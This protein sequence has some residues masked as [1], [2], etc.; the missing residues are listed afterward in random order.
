MGDL[1]MARPSGH[2]LSWPHSLSVD[3]DP[4]MC[5][6]LPDT[7]C[8]LGFRDIAHLAVLLLLWLPCLAS[9]SSYS[10]APL[11]SMSFPCP[12]SFA[13][14]LL[15]CS[16]FRCSTASYR[17]SLL[18]LS[19]EVVSSKLM[20]LNLYAVYLWPDTHLEFQVHGLPLISPWKL[21]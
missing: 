15:S 18:C 19:S 8:P 9:I 14:C 12:A 6:C 20:A 10:S 2:L 4:A 5:T 16:S 13:V 21:A 17:F 11:A 1:C 3:L 7:P